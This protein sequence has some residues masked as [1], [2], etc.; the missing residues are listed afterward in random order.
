MIKKNLNDNPNCD[1]INLRPFMQEDGCD[2]IIQIIKKTTGEQYQDSVTGFI[3]N[4]DW[5]KKFGIKACLHRYISDQLKPSLF[6]QYGCYNDKIPNLSQCAG[7]VCTKKN[8]LLTAYN[9]LISEIGHNNVVVKD[10]Y[11]CGGDD[12]FF[13]KD[14]KEIEEFKWKDTYKLIEIEEDLRYVNNGG[15]KKVEKIEFVGITFEANHVQ[16]IHEQIISGDAVFEGSSK[17][18]NKE[19][20]DLLTTISEAVIKKIGEKYMG[21]FDFAIQT[22]KDNT[23][24][25]YLIDMNTGRYTASSQTYAVIKKFNIDLNNKYFIRKNVKINQNV[26]F[27][28]L[29]EKYPQLLFNQNEKTGIF[30]HTFYPQTQYCV[31]SIFGNDKQDAYHKLEQFQKIDWLISTKK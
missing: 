18:E 26:A 10:C 13:C 11:G 19:I 20:S 9:K 28:Q 3:A 6:E 29:Q 12:I 22:L 15:G 25:I 27:K 31:L 2:D 21:G 17:Y 5:Y 14:E 1:K 24:K 7:Y 23:K 4:K 16:L 8:E 30:F